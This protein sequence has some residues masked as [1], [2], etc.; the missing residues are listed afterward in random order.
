MP[1]VAQPFHRPNRNMWFVHFNGREEKLSSDKQEA[2]RLYYALMSREP[3]L[4]RPAPD[5]LLVIALID[6]FMEWARCNRSPATYDIYLRLIQQFATAIPK[7]LT[8]AELKPFHVTRVMDANSAN[9]SQNTKRDFAATV[10]RAFNWAERQGIIEKNPLKNLEKP[11]A[12]ARELVVNPADYARILEAVKE[13]NF[14]ELIELAWETGCRPVELR[15]I[16]ARHVDQDRIVFP[17]TEAKGK[18]KHRVIY[19]GTDKAKEIVARLCVA[20]PTGCIL[21]NSEGRPWVKDAI[22]CAFFRLKKKLGIKF[23]MGAFRKGF[24]TE[25]LKNGVDVSTLAGLMGHANGNMIASVYSKV[26]QDPVWMAEAAKRA[27]A[28]RK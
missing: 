4:A 19:L 1:K 21:L 26:A 10:Q 7:T 15:K 24:V 3:E 14:R 23:H 2:Y 22:N 28:T 9:W 6:D 5:R 8:V 11:A 18:R 12:V 27:K 13:P 20:N 25:A 16:E 17:P